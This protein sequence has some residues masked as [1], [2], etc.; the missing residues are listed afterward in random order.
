MAAP[1]SQRITTTMPPSSWDVME[2]RLKQRYLRIMHHELDRTGGFEQ[3]RSWMQ[4]W[5][6]LTPINHDDDY[7]PDTPL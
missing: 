7:H 3:L 4:W 6:V 2:L 1:E 5:Q